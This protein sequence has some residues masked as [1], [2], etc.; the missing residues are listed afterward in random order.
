MSNGRDRDRRPGGNLEATVRTVTGSDGKLTMRAHGGWVVVE[1]PPP[2][3][4]VIDPERQLPE[5]LEN[6]RIIGEVALTQR[7]TR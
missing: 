3:S 7:P 5:V 1:T 6:L 4:F 2:G